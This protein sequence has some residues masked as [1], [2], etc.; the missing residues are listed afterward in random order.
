MGWPFAAPTFFDRY[1]L[2]HG[3]RVKTVRIG[4]G[5]LA[6]TVLR[7]SFG[8]HRQNRKDVEK[9]WWNSGDGCGRPA[10]FAVRALAGKAFMMGAVPSVPQIPVPQI[11]RPSR[12][13]PRVVSLKSLRITIPSASSFRKF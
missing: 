9:R 10:N 8:V 13:F 7:R 12:K 5:L 6:T 2:F 1:I 11:P 4:G 3:K